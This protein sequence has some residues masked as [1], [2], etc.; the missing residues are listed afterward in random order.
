MQVACYSPSQLHGVLLFEANMSKN[1]LVF[2]VGVN[3]ADYAVCK[4]S[5]GRRTY[6]P[7]YLKWKSMIQRCY[8]K[9]FHKKNPTYKGCF[10]CEEW[11]IFSNFKRWMES[12]DWKG[13]SIDKDLLYPGNR[14][15]SPKTCV[16]IS[17]KI[18]S[19]MTEANSA[20]GELMIGVSYCKSRGLYE[21]NCSNP[22]TGKPEKK[23]YFNTELDAHNFWGF[24]KCCMAL[25]LA[26]AEKNKAV[27]DALIARYSKYLIFS[28]DF[29]N[30]EL[31]KERKQ[32][33]RPAQNN[34]R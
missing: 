21:S 18:N 1:K 16:F 13:K 25:E 27:K 3:D 24:R 28:K 33:I 29:L 11:K 14:V 15:Y 12:Q 10:V 7:F 19:F 23:R 22:I 5:L 4:S 30:E 34:L 32:L 2:G 31:A 6:C 8:S 20:R 9:E 17:T 26:K